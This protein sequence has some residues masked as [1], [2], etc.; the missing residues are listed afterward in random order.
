MLFGDERPSITR[1]DV[2]E[3]YIEYCQFMMDRGAR[4][5]HMARHILGLYSGQRGARLYRRHLSENTPKRG[6]KVNL[7]SEAVAYTRAYPAQ[8]NNR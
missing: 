5:N 1:E 7:L 3:E 8:V 4:L 2:I 6:A